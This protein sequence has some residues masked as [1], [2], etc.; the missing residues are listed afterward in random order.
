MK[1]AS[2]SLITLSICILWTKAQSTVETCNAYVCGTT[3]S[4]CAVK[5]K[6]NVYVNSNA[7]NGKIIQINYNRGLRVLY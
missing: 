1:S 4:K 3:Y 6:T 2:Y 5:D 7:C